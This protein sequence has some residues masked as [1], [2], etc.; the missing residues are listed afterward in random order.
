MQMTDA[1]QPTPLQ[2]NDR[3]FDCVR[4][5]TIPLTATAIAKALDLPK[6]TVNKVLY[7]QQTAG[8][9]RQLLG[10]SKAPL[11][12]VATGTST[13][14]KAPCVSCKQPGARV[15]I[16]VP[17]YHAI[18]CD[19]CGLD[20]AACLTPGCGQAIS[21]RLFGLVQAEPQQVAQILGPG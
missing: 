6:A 17:C 2:L 21:Q 13:Q 7:A 12:A 18:T 19:S 20:N 15:V 3:V 9:V 8:I 4:Q 10:T 16:N 1:I 14:H 5:S 11:W